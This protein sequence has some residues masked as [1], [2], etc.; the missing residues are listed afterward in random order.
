MAAND[1]VGADGL[2]STVS[3]SE[4]SAKSRPISSEVVALTCG[5]IPLVSLFNFDEAI[6]L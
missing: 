1:L 5:K 3:T 4:E 6:V 2:G